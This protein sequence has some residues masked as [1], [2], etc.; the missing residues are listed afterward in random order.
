MRRPIPPTRKWTRRST[1]SGRDS[2]RRNWT[3]RCCRPAAASI[4]CAGICA[5]NCGWTDLKQ[6]FGSVQPSEA[7][8]A[9]YYRDHT[10]EFGRRTEQEAHDTILALLTTERR[11]ALV[12]D[13]AAGLRRRANVNIL[14]R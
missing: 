6:R 7:D 1:Q 9:Q 11:Q 14:P 2:G 12:R 13:W 3:R 10:A 4:S 8:I 5:T